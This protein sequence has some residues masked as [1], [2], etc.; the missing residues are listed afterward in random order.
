MTEARQFRAIVVGIETYDDKQVWKTLTGVGQTAARVARALNAEPLALPNG[1]LKDE[2][3]RALKDAIKA[4]PDR[5][6][7]FLHWIGHGVSAG[8]QHYLVCR[9]SPEPSALDSYEAIPSGE[10]GRILAASKAERVVVVLDTCFSGDGAGNLAQRYRDSLA[11]ELDREGWERVACVIAASHPLDK[12]VAGRFSIALAE[13]LEDPSLHLKW[14]RAEQYIDPER[15]AIAVRD[16]LGEAN[17]AVHPRFSKE[18]FG[19]DIIPNP[20]YQPEEG[21]TDLETRRRLEGVFG[22]AA[23]FNLSA[24]GIE[25]G[26]AGYFFTGRRQS[27]QAIVD[28]L[29]GSGGNLLVVTGPPGVGKSALIGRMVTLSVPEVRTEIAAAGGL[30]TDDLLPPDN[31][32]HV[33]IHAKGKSVFDVATALGRAAGLERPVVDQ[34]GIVE[35]LAALA[36]NGKQRTIVIDALDEAAQG[37]AERIANEI[38]RPVIAMPHMRMLVGS[39]RSLDGQFIPDG[40]ERHER[41]LKSFGLS[42][43]ILDLAD[44]P[45]A[46]ADIAEFTSKRLHSAESRGGDDWIEQAA[47]RVADASNGSFLYARLAA[48]SLEAFPDAVLEQLPADAAEAFVLDIA[49]RFSDDVARVSDLLRSLAFGLGL[50]LSRS[51]W[52]PIATA[53]AA[54]PHTYTDDDVVWILRNAGSYIIETTVQTGGIGQ[55]VYRLIH[56]AIAD[57]LQKACPTSSPNALIMRALMHGLEGESWLAADAYIARHL[58]EHAAQANHEPSEDVCFDR[59]F[60]HPGLLAIA[61]PDNFLRLLGYAE[62]ARARAVRDIY[63]LAGAELRVA[64]AVERWA[65]LHRTAM[66]QRSD[67]TQWLTPPGSS[68]WQSA[69]AQTAP[70]IPHL[71]VGRH[72]AKVRSVALG[73]FDGRAVI[74]SGGEDQTVRLWDAANGSPFG[75]PLIGHENVVTSVALG[76]ISG[77]T[78]IASG[79]RDQTVRLW[80]AA[81]GTPFGAPL[82]GHADSVTSVALGVV[83]RRIVIVS[84]SRDQTVRLWD[85]IRGQPLSAPLAGHRS[86][87]TSVALGVVNGRMVVVSG[88]RDLT[89]RLWDAERG[90]PLGYPL[91][92]HGSWVTSVALG[93]V[94]GR[95]VIVSGGEDQTVRLWDAASGSPLGVPLRAHAGSVS[96]VGIGVVDGRAVIVSGSRDQTVQL[97]DA[98]SGASLGGPFSGHESWVTSVALGVVDGRTVIISAGDDKTVRLWDAAS[99]PPRSAPLTGHEFWVGSAASGVVDG[100]TVIVSGGGDQTVRLWDAASGTPIGTPLAGHQYWV[101]S[102]ALGVVD[103]RA[104]VVSGS[105]DETVRL[106]DAASGTPLGAPLAGHE[107]MVSSVALGAIDGRTVIIS[108]GD[109]QTV[110]L[111]DAVSGAS[112]GAPLTGHENMVTSVALGL[113]DGRAVIVSGSEDQTLRLWDA[114]SGLPLGAPL[115]GHENV[116]TSVALGE[117]SGRTIIASG[118]RDQTVRL[119]DAASGT[120]FGAPLTGHAD[121]VTSVALG[122]VGGRTVV[123]SGSSDETI[124]VWDART[125][126]ALMKCPIGMKIGSVVILPDSHIVAATNR[127]VISLQVRI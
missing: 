84:G 31:S 110:R 94:D 106:W 81:S 9:D 107:N 82:T 79:S 75:V 58:A 96:S 7:V 73:A 88:G 48:R 29:G 91:T 53:L 24:R 59:L 103:G 37:Q 114:A 98:S 100:R 119:W 117:I 8:D 30:H 105:W 95:A 65:L 55:A 50:G 71:V 89:V 51:V 127:G 34:P 74:V 39:R 3:P 35:A 17:K 124:Q 13:A 4:I 2:A 99:R 20:R 47:T 56:Q 108:A 78:I 5:A 11:L 23:H 49:S 109:D 38:I 66:F 118:S 27:Q 40:E 28:W 85:A 57:H 19:Q 36:E 52:A 102:V 76:E 123:V 115:I 41:L 62:G 16:M 64:E 83:N 63:R 97:W 42:A 122:V 121:S 6:T 26:E 45:E 80:D 22:E 104:V 1:G 116:V 60:D 46:R 92:G 44:E 15:L 25:T 111:W 21:N 32:V 70:A 14:T 72:K 18:G 12:A 69:W 113:V 86:W 120:P 90:Q 10:L 68:P 61:V 54:S 126:E 112:L 101:S 33:A 43:N 67:L 93:E 77:R 125:G 87:V